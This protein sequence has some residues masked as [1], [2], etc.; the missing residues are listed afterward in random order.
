MISSENFL[1]KFIPI[2]LI[3]TFSL[4][5]WGSVALSEQYFTS[6]EFP[7][8]ITDV[9]DGYSLAQ[10][11]SKTINVSIKG[12]GWQL[13]GL[14]MGREYTMSITAE[15]K[16]GKQ[17][18][19]SRKLI[20]ENSWLFGSAQIV[21]V[22]PIVINYNIEKVSKKKVKVIPDVELN[23]KEGFGLVS[24]LLTDPDSVYIFGPHS[25]LR[26]TDSIK[27][28]FF[29]TTELN[30][31]TVLEL[32]L[33]PPSDIKLYLEKVMLNLNIQKIVDRDFSNVAVET[34]K[35]PPLR[36]LQLYPSKVK[37]VLRGGINILGKLD[38]SEVVSYVTFTQALND[39]LGFIEP[40]IEV[41]K[42]V[43]V[44]D[45]KPSRLEYIIKKY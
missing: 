11:S 19:E 27:T 26:L 42:Y 29:K 25:T 43:R 45:V 23:F 44:I 18:I 9:D 28:S 33:I 1:K 3:T 34:R 20:D 39:T 32:E 8:T 22:S 13:A 21:D 41:P 40:V 5:L 36:E 35:V 2:S 4:I 30:K 17:S 14:N 31:S 38:P 24:E 37:I 6:M 12:I 7:L 16:K 15:N 10:L